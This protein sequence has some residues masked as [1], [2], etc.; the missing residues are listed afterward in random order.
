MVRRRRILAG[1]GLLL[2]AIGTAALLFPEIVYTRFI[3]KYFWGPVVADAA[4]A[5]TATYHGVT[6]HRGYNI[7]NEI[8]YGLLLG[9]ALLLLITV[10]DRFDVGREPGF[11]LQFIPFIIGGG[12][13][14]V[15]EDASVGGTVAGP[16]QYLLISP[17]IYWTMFVVVLATLL[18]SLYGARHS[19]LPD[20]RYGVAGIGGLF[21]LGV[22]GLLSTM[23]SVTHAWMLLA[24]PAIA[25]GVFLLIYGLVAGM[26][27]RAPGL[28]RL[29]RP[30]GAAVMLG[31]LLDAAAT[32]LSLELLGYG[33]KHPLVAFFVKISGTAY[34]F[35]GLKAVVIGGIV[36]AMDEEMRAD[37]PLF[38]NLVLVGIL[39]VGLGPGVRNTVR[40]FFG[41]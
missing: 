22:F 13:L 32:A 33:E 30:E 34:A 35:I 3:W 9:Y 23:A 24:A 4:G 6:A 31:H 37:D 40:A 21:A 17:I 36:Y 29:V 8:G 18:I 1:G 2:A 27:G 19:I 25:G 10:L 12:L 11:A 5:A 39:A 14:R 15:V 41:V 28:Q 7:V 16:A 20:Y 26:G 38:Y